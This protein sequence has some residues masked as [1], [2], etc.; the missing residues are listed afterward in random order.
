MSRFYNR[1]KK[2]FRFLRH[3]LELIIS[4]ARGWEDVSRDSENPENL[5]RDGLYP[6][7]AVMAATCFVRLAYAHDDATVTT[8]LEQ[9][10]TLFAVYFAMTFVGPVILMAGIDRGEMTDGEPNRKRVATLCVYC[11]AVMALCQMI[12]N[13][14]PHVYAVIQILPVYVLLLIGKSRRYIGILP[15]KELQYLLLAGAVII[16]ITLVLSYLLGMFMP[17]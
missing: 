15:D 9:A 13:F 11:L 6:F 16:G 4:P 3:I 14:I 5:C 10:I 8:C 17:R 12:A 7:F 2:M 1:L